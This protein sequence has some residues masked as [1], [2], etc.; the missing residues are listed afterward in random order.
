MTFTCTASIDKIKGFTWYKDEEL[1]TTGVTRV[2]DNSSRLDL[3]ISPSS[4][5]I[6]RCR[7]DGPGVGY[8][9]A[10]ASMKG[11][12]GVGEEGKLILNKTQHCQCTHAP[13]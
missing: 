11:L 1:T 6:Y 4:V 13:V 7:V 3:T 8:W 9:I 12:P 2:S 10:E 5:G